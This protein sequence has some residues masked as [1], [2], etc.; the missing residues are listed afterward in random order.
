MDIWTDILSRQMVHTSATTFAHFAGWSLGSLI[1]NLYYFNQWLIRY[2]AQRVY[3]TTGGCI[4]FESGMS[5][6]SCCERM[7][8]ANAILVE[9]STNV[10]DFP[11]LRTPREPGLQEIR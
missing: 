11:L 10:H 4:S 9:Y 8:A 3:H 2:G 5:G 1:Y 6:E 7:V